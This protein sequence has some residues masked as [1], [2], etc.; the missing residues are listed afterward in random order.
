MS[1]S[2]NI[3]PRP[4]PSGV[5]ADQQAVSDEACIASQARSP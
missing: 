3:A 2:T 5:D 1:T 4:R